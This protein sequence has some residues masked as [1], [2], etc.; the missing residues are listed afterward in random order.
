MSAQCC[1][2]PYSNDVL[3]WTNTHLVGAT[4][5]AQ[6]HFTHLG[7]PAVV[8][9]SDTQLMETIHLQVMERLEHLTPFRILGLQRK[10]IQYMTTWPCFSLPDAENSLQ[11]P[12]I[13]AL[14]YRGGW[15][16]SHVSACTVTLKGRVI[17][18][19]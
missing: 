15:S 7:V 9:R 2:V 11:I 13:R 14:G 4:V 8:V 12:Q 18:Q 5:I 16:Q 10:H 1:Y 19:Y 17:R 3:Q 6:L